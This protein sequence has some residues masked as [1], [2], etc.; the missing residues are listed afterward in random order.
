MSSQGQRVPRN[1]SCRATGHRLGAGCR[2]GATGTGRK[3]APGDGRAGNKWLRDCGLTPQLQLSCRQ[4][5]KRRGKGEGSGEGRGGARLWVP[6]ACVERRRAA[7]R[8]GLCSAPD[9]PPRSVCSSPSHLRVSPPAQRLI[10]GSIAAPGSPRAACSPL[11][12][13]TSGA[14]RVRTRRAPN[15]PRLG[16]RALHA[17]GRPAP[18]RPAQRLAA[19][20][21]VL[22][23]RIAPVASAPLSEPPPPP[24]KS[25]IN[26]PSLPPPRSAPATQTPPPDAPSL[27]S[28]AP[29]PRSPRLPSPTQMLHPD[30]LGPARTPGRGAVPSWALRA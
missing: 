24:L 22:W 6:C 7:P 17:R 2:V 8:L 14:R 11:A 19:V 9:R 26:C 25:A 28:S 4:A 15:V 10:R 30:Q 1:Q 18:P 21:R 29:S 12:A 27:T 5:G 13:A 3:E 20:A 16:T 23:P